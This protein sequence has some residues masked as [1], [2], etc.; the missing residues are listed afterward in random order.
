MPAFH[1]RQDAIYVY[2][3]VKIHLRCFRYLLDAAPLRY[4]DDARAMVIY[5]RC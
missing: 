1:Y 2:V 4:S 5:R 3:A